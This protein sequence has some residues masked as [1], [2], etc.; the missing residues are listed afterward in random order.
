MQGIQRCG[1]LLSV[2]PAN[3]PCTLVVNDLHTVG[4]FPPSPPNSCLTLTRRDTLQ[5]RRQNSCFFF[6][7]TKLQLETKN[8]S[9]Q[10]MFSKVGSFPENHYCIESDRKKGGVRMNSHREQ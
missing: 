7:G 1:F 9:V 2:G 5:N 4:R 8:F 10:S 6:G 3:D